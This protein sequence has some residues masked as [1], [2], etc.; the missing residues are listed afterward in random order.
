MTEEHLDLGRPPRPPRRGRWAGRG[1]KIALG[2]VV[3]GLV[4]WVVWR[5]VTQEPPAT[6]SPP[7]PTSTQTGFVAH[8][9]PAIPYL[10]S[11][12]L[13]PPD[14]EARGLPPGSW[15]DF[16]QLADGRVVLV[17]RESLTVIGTAGEGRTYDHTGD[18]TAR[19]DGTAVAWTGHDGRVR[20]LD[21]GH[22][23]PTVVRDGRQLAPACRGLRVAG[24]LEPG[25]Q[26]CDRDGG[27]L[28]PDGSYFASIGVQTV[29]LA[30]PDDIT[31]GTSTAFLGTIRD[32]VWEDAAHLLVVMVVGDR[33]H[34]V[35]IS[36]LGNSED[37]ISP[38]HGAADR[39]R[40]VL[41]LPL[42]NVSASVQP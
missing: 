17:Q 38:V 10:R 16:A 31:G 2:V 1:P 27:L 15:S 4:G 9:P 29:T 41:V 23:D 26:T 6:P 20:R 18:L 28:S 22:A 40:P 14:G 39:S 36:T 37:L 7:S 24:R 3:L 19:P 42:T 21:S 30:P 32:A 13:V 35:R 12:T 11:G 8:E 25:W 34:L 5:G 33:A